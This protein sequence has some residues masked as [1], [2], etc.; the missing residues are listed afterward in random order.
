MSDEALVLDAGVEYPTS[1]GRPVAET[2]LHYQRLADAAHALNTRF[3]S[4]PGV[5]VGVNMLVYDQQGNPRR[6]LSPDLFVAFDVEDRERDIYKLW[7]DRSPS[8]VLELTS[9]STRGEDERKKARYSRWGVAEY[10][11]YDPRA[12]YV[13]PLLQGF[14]LVGG[15]YR[16]MATDVLPNGK[17][18]FTSKTVGLGL[19]LDRSVLRFYDAQTGRNFETLGE[20]IAGRREDGTRLREYETLLGEAETKRREA[21]TKRREAETKQREAENELAAVK[22]RFGIP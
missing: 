15:G 22:A 4:Q 13:K 17:R 5:Y 11:L 3:E 6:H 20:V 19:W 2:P 8:F 12:E 14:E 16:A 18:G 10:F 9:K 7:E 1:D 21:E